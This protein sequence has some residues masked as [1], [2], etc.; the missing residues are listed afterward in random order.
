MCGLCALKGA[1]YTH[2]T[3]H[4]YVTQRNRSA[5][6]C[7][8]AIASRSR[9]VVC[10]LFT[11]A[12]PAKERT[13][14][15]ISG[16]RLTSLRSVAS[17]LPGP[18]SATAAVVVFG[19]LRLTPLRYVASAPTGPTRSATP[20]SDACVGESTIH[21][22]NSGVCVSRAGIACVSAS[23]M[24]DQPCGIPHVMRITCSCVLALSCT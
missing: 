5:L 15:K 20:H 14:E 12:G 16:L 10:F 9:L 11:P 18:R 1:H 13:K 21:L 24:R 19:V 6:P 2:V 3:P 22:P 23:I 4:V 8:T 17:D 7:C